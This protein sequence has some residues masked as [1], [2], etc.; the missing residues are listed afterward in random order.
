MVRTELLTPALEFLEI[1]KQ[2][3]TG[4]IEATVRASV[5]VEELAHMNRIRFS[6]SI[7]RK[8]CGGIPQREYLPV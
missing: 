8:F 3:W 4:I 7:M 5:E 1:P 6:T 2:K